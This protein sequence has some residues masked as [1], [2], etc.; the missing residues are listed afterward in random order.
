MQSNT[1]TAVLAERAI[2]QDDLVPD[3]DES[4]DV[5]DVLKATKSKEEG[6]ARLEAEGRGPG[7]RRPG[8]RE[9]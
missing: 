2:D 9:R 5:L 7:R 3:E 6:L 4:F 8:R 1:G